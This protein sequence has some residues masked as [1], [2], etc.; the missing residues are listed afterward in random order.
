MREKSKNSIFGVTTPAAG[1]Y[2][3]G[4]DNEYAGTAGFYI[5][6]AEQKYHTSY[7][8]GGATLLSGQPLHLKNLQKIGR[9]SIL[10]LSDKTC[11]WPIGDPA[12]EDFCLCGHGPKNGSPYC[13]YHARLAYQ[14][15]EKQRRN[16]KTTTLDEKWQPVEIKTPKI[17]EVIIAK[18]SSTL[19]TEE[20]I[21]QL[22]NYWAN[23]LSASQI[24]TKLGNGLTRNAIIGKVH[25]LNLGGRGPLPIPRTADTTAPAGTSETEELAGKQN[26]KSV[27]ESVNQYDITFYGPNNSLSVRHRTR[28]LAWII[29]PDIKQLTFGSQIFSIGNGELNPIA[30]TISPADGTA[31]EFQV[32]L[33]LDD[34]FSRPD[35]VSVSESLTAIGLPSSGTVPCEDFPYLD[36]GCPIDIVVRSS[37]ASI[38]FSEALQNHLDK[39]HGPDSRTIFV[40]D[41]SIAPQKESFTRLYNGKTG[42]RYDKPSVVLSASIVLAPKNSTA[43]ATTKCPTIEELWNKVVGHHL[44]T[45]NEFSKLSW[46]DDLNLSGRTAKQQ[47][48][49]VPWKIAVSG[50]TLLELVDQLHLPHESKSLLDKPVSIPTLKGVG[51]TDAPRGNISRDH[52][53]KQQRVWTQLE[54]ALADAIEA[55]GDAAVL[56]FVKSR[57][58]TAF[59]TETYARSAVE[60]ASKNDQTYS[61]AEIIARFGEAAGQIPSAKPSKLRPL[62]GREKW[63]LPDG[64]RRKETPL[65]FIERVYPDRRAHG[66]TMADLRSLDKSLHKSFE[67]WLRIHD[68]QLTND[69]GLPT[70]KDQ[71]DKLLLDLKEGSP[72]PLPLDRLSKLLAV[73]KAREHLGIRQ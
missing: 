8:L 62:E 39:I 29:P 20:R 48:S 61:E 33:M 59:S 56:D 1:L 35:F 53:L 63:R 9:I 19:W 55:E 37:R 23:G 26:S 65:E 64:K 34:E 5:P 15:D 13:E 47:A 30:T 7:E 12:S 28:N 4:E 16:G 60:V 6:Q 42:E 58:G 22:Q 36:D 44:R 27:F 68:H 2:P 54:A 72:L 25:R 18:E 66:M 17:S 57:L 10:H 21:S 45:N 43:A 50:P 38:S 14:P 41:I 24:A 31:R 73:K 69:F 51:R 67:N 32:A 40:L 3:E 71:N 46:Q 70:L 49:A 11:K 52:D